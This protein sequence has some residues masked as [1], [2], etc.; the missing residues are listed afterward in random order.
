MAIGTVLTALSLLKD[1]I[2]ALGKVAQRFLDG[3]ATS[4]EL[5]SEASKHVLDADTQLALAQIQLNT[6]EAEH[7]SLFV[8]GWR[9]FV[10]WIAAL[11]FAAQVI[12]FPLLQF[13]F[14]GQPVPILDTELVYMTLGGLLG[15]GSMRTYEKMKKVNRNNML[16]DY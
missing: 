6:K 11:G 13:A 1:T 7:A 16:E 8:A 9:P 4:E 2:P 14:P 5:A 15:L 3:K 10:G 12:L